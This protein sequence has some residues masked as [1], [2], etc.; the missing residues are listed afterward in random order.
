MKIAIITQESHFPEDSLLVKAAQ[1]NNHT[2]DLIDVKNIV[3]TFGGSPQD[4]GIFY[5]GKN[6]AEY[7]LVIIRFAFASIKRLIGMIKYLRAKGVKVADNDIENVGYNI[8]KARDMVLFSNANLPYPKSYSVE[9]EDDFRDACMDLQFPVVAKAINTGKGKSVYMFQNMEEV[10]DFILELN[11]KSLKIKNYIVQE[12]IP[13]KVD[14][15]VLVI[16]KKVVGAMQRIPKEGDFRANYSRGGTVQMYPM[17]A[18]IHDIV[19]K[20][21]AA[22]RAGNAGVD[23]LLTDDKMYVLEVNR[24]PGIEG[25]ATASGFDIAEMMLQDA[26]NNSF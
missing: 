14:L 19:L 7:D 1:Q 24:T 13:Y 17:T 3:M 10:D 5:L 6:L 4:Q 9:N 20:A 16:G 2:C 25:F 21:C 8:D 23:L 22:T 11:E 18:E 15:R 26:L 12:F